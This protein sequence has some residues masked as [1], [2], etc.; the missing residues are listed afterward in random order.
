MRDPDLFRLLHACYEVTHREF[1]VLTALRRGKST[2]QI[3]IEL[4]I[5]D[6]AVARHVGTLLERLGSPDRDSL[7]SL[8]DR[9]SSLRA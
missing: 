8:V 7:V 5:W 9:I 6:S 3:G 4:G 1:E 2:K